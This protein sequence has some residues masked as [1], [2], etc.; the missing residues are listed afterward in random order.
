MSSYRNVV[1]SRK[2]RWQLERTVPLPPSPV[3]AAE[4]YDGE[5]LLGNV[6]AHLPDKDTAMLPLS[7]PAGAASGA[8]RRSSSARYADLLSAGEGAGVAAVG[9]VFAGH[10]DPFRVCMFAFHRPKLAEWA[11]LVAA[12]GAWR[13]S[14]S[15]PKPVHYMDVLLPADV[16]PACAP[17]LRIPGLFGAR[18]HQLQIGETIIKLDTKSDINYNGRHHAKFWREGKCFNIT[19]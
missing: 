7:P 17:E 5:D 1:P 6:V 19:R 18:T 11:R 3:S 4:G 8:P 16:K 15:S 14:S 13:I 9:R 12:K 2:R 10:P